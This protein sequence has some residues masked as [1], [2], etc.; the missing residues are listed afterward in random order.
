MEKAG[1]GGA[2]ESCWS[3]GYGRQVVSESQAEKRKNGQNKS[4][5]GLP[6]GCAPPCRYVWAY[7]GGLVYA[8]YLARRLFS[9]KGF[10]HSVCCWKNG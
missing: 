2:L 5:S 1:K 10:E 8:E 7:K 3:G 6:C 4:V 9:Q